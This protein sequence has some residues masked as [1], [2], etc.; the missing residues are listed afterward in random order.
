MQVGI[1]IGSAYGHDVCCTWGNWFMCWAQRK[2]NVSL[3]VSNY[4]LLFVF[5]YWLLN[6]L[7]KTIDL[8]K[9]HHCSSFKYVCI[10]SQCLIPILRQSKLVKFLLFLTQFALSCSIFQLC[11]SFNTLRMPSYKLIPFITSPFKK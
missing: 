5:I 7:Q 4:H 10:F 9:S 2:R 1:G 6:T 11:A 8:Q 3:P